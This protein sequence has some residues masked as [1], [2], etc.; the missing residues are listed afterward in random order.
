M[1]KY[2]KKYWLYTMLAP[3]FMAGEVFLDLLQ[4]RLMR[5]IVDEGV[6]GLSNNYVGDLNLVVNIGLKMIG[7]V[8]LGACAGILSG[9]FANLAGQYFANDVRKDAFRKIMSLSLGQTDIFSTG[10]LI[11]R[12]T[13]D[14][15]Q[16]QG[17]VIQIFRGFF[18]HIFMFAGGVYYLVKLAPGYSVVIACALPLVAVC[19]V[20]FVSKATPVFLVLQRKLDRINSIMQENVSGSRVVKAYVREE[21]EKKRFKQSNDELIESQLKILTLFSFMSPILNIIMNLSVAAIIYVGGIQVREGNITPGTVMAAITYITQILNSVMMIAMI[22]QNLTRGS[23]SIKRLKELFTVKPL[24]K[25]GEFAGK[26]ALRGQIEFRNVSFSY[27]GGSGEKVL[28]GINLM[29]HPGETVGILGATGSG[30][31]TLVSLIPRFYDPTE[32]VVLVDGIDVKEYKLQCLREKIAIA[33]QKSELFT[34]TVRENISWG[35]PEAKEDEIKKAAGIAIAS[36]FIEDMKDAY[37]T[38]V[39]EKGMNFSG[40]Q[41][42]RVSISRA[43][44]KQAEILI[45]DDSTSALDLKTESMLYDEIDREYAGQTKIIIAQRVASVWKADR[46]AVIDSG[47]I[48]ACDSHENLLASCDIYKDIVNSQ[49]KAGG[50]DVG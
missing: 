39:A 36:G 17:M 33:L 18:R 30:K 5:L 38:L 21:Y 34:T 31:T 43:I 28:S 47:K 7:L 27:P 11:T 3:L 24:I 8:L 45:L 44:L 20:F 2:L 14:V 49:L 41:K 15:S 26:T 50:G 10:S 29:I 13:N 35:R 48:A 9:F 4:P 23:V 16:V 19:V 42:Q 25:E 46:I 37:E 12:V 1:L 22:L 32:G 40:G 6:L